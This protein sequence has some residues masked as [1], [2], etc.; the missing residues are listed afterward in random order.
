M[1][2][3]TSHVSEGLLLS[4]ISHG[5]KHNL[6][7]MINFNHYYDYICTLVIITV[8]VKEPLVLNFLCF[9]MDY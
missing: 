1:M 5:L 4:C 7:T 3:E 8:M 6:M 9:R 2:L